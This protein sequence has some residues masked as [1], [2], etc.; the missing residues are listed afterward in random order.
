MT[1]HPEDIGL[2][3]WRQFKPTKTFQLISSHTWGF[4]RVF[5]K[6]HVTLN[7]PCHLFKVCDSVAFSVFMVGCD[8]RHSSSPPQKNPAPLKR[9]AL[10]SPSP[11]PGNRSSPRASRGFALGDISI[12]D[13]RAVCARLLSLG[14]TFSGAPR[15]VADPNAPRRPWRTVLQPAAARAPSLRSFIDRCLGFPA[16]VC[17]SSNL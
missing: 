15:G 17:V 11:A 9:W 1:V 10:T 8:H 5:Y 14:I 6:I 2:S 3:A 12:N 4:S 13:R 7:L 16:S